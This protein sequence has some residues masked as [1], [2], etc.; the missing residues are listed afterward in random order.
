MSKIPCLGRLSG[1]RLA[2]ARHIGSQ[3]LRE[4]LLRLRSPRSSRRLARSP[5]R[6]SRSQDARRGS[7]PRGDRTFVLPD[8]QAMCAVPSAVCLW[9]ARH[10]ARCLARGPARRALHGTSAQ[11]LL[12]SISATTS[13][14]ANSRF[15]MRPCPSRTWVLSS[16]MPLL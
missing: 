2:S 1:C 14:R 8:G 5:P 11:P 3:A 7:P 15:A 12:R 13:E 6:C 9:L 4:A 10:L 16:A